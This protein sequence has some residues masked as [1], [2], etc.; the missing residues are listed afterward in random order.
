[1]DLFRRKNE[2]DPIMM[3]LGPVLWR[4]NLETQARVG[5]IVKDYNEFRKLIEILPKKNSI[6]W[7]VPEVA[8]S[9][10]LRLDSLPSFLFEVPVSLLKLYYAFQKPPKPRLTGD[11]IY[12]L[13]LKKKEE[14]AKRQSAMMA[15]L[16]LKNS[17]R[18][19]EQAQRMNE[20]I[21]VYCAPYYKDS[22]AFSR[23]LSL[24]QDMMTNFKLI[25]DKN[26]L[27]SIVADTYL[28]FIADMIYALSWS[29][30]DLPRNYV[31]VHAPSFISSP[32][33]RYEYE[34]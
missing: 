15:V 32:P 29:G 34:L 1:L 27:A 19:E 12:Q 13:E 25:Q 2:F 24:W 21:V 4:Q 20:L 14:F 3:T 7:E 30:R 8:L 18:P 11:Q 10:A 6:P 9:L 33:P 17:G 16:N 28:D 26:K 31:Y 22:P 23:A 5:Q